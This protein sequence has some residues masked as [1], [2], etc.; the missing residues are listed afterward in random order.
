VKEEE[1]KERVR[2]RKNNCKRL[3]KRRKTE[4]VIFGFRVSLYEKIPPTVKSVSFQACFV[5]ICECLL[6]VEIY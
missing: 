5:K 4:V 2:M 1:E 6:F 3:R